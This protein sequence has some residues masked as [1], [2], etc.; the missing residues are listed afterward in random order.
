MI[1]RRTLVAGL[2]VLLMSVLVYLAY[3]QLEWQ[4]QTFD[5]GPQKQARQNPF[6]AA[7]LFLATYGIDVNIEQGY[8]RLDAS[9]EQFPPTDE[10]VVISDGYASLSP[11]RAD[12][13]LAWVEQ[14]GHLMISASNPFIHNLDQQHDEVFSRFG[15][16]LQQAGSPLDGSILGLLSDQ[17]QSKPDANESGP[18]VDEAAPDKPA[19]PDDAEALLESLAYWDPKSACPDPGS[20]TGLVMYQNEADASDAV[21]IA[22]NFNTAIGLNFAEE[23]QSEISYWASNEQGVQFI[24]Q[25]YGRGLVSFI[26]STDIWKNHNIAC[27]DNAY[28]LQ[29]FASNAAKVWL[30]VN[31]THPSLISLL[32]QRAPWFV[33]VLLLLVLLGIWHYGL[34]FGAMLPERPIARRKIIEHIDASAVFLWRDRRSRLQLIQVVQNNIRRKLKRRGVRF[35]RLDSDL[36]ARWLA[37][38]AGV[39][40]VAVLQAMQKRNASKK[41]MALKEH[42]FVSLMK[43][44]K[45]IEDAL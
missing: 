12:K 41:P 32:W 30:L 7:S 42:E 28:F 26:T 1:A 6:L 40:Q 20:N 35:D 4:E 45:Q 37:D 24:Q 16:W 36:Q 10:M 33:G 38:K 13:L 25:P 14:G 5:L 27:V 21:Q 9:P 29:F 3:T 43:I 39:D 23:Q 34:R 44:L 2:I 15:I 18:A 17:D 8:T 19:P 11:L 31:Q 22:I